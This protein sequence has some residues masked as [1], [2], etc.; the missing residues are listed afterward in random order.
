[1]SIGLPDHDQGA[2]GLRGRPLLYSVIASDV[3]GVGP[4]EIGRLD[5]AQ[6]SVTLVENSVAVASCDHL[7]SPSLESAVS[8]AE[9]C[10]ALFQIFVRQFEIEIVA[11]TLQNRQK[12]VFIHTRTFH[13]LY[14]FH[15]CIYS[16]SD[17]RT[18]KRIR[19]VTVC[20]TCTAR[21]CYY[22]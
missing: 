19:Y 22:V 11:D 10:V 15:T 5:A 20:D 13:A 17:N 8:V 18:D 7:P 9:V 16:N 6:F 21:I 1:M 3:S 2:L 12:P 14:T 4:R